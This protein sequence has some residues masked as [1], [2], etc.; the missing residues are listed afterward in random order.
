MEGTPRCREGERLREPLPGVESPGAAGQPRGERAESRSLTQ[1]TE[2]E[3]NEH[4]GLGVVTFQE[5]PKEECHPLGKVVGPEGLGQVGGRRAS[6]TVLSL[7]APLRW[8]SFVGQDGKCWQSIK[9]RDWQEGSS[10]VSPM[11]VGP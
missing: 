6:V 4:A 8:G 10:D 5:A 3:I 1:E 9:G 11:R 2:H 7:L